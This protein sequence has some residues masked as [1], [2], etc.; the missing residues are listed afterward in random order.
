MKTPV[1][2]L[3]D[4]DLSDHDVCQRILAL[5]KHRLAEGLVVESLFDQ[6]LAAFPQNG[7]D[8]APV[9][10]DADTAIA[11]NP[12]GRDTYAFVWDRE[13]R[14]GLRRYLIALGRRYD[15][16]L[17]RF[18][19][20]E[21]TF[22]TTHIKDGK[23]VSDWAP[24]YE[25]ARDLSGLGHEHDVDVDVSV[26]DPKRINQ[27]FWGYLSA[28]Y[29]DA[30]G[31]RVV[32][33]RIFLNFGIQP[34][35]R[36]VWNIDRVYLQG[37]QIWHLEIKH[38]YPITGRPLTFGLNDGELRLI[39]NLSQCGLRSLHTII[40]KPRWNK[41]TSSMLL[42]NDMSA[43]AAAAVIGREITG[44][45]VTAIMRQRAGQ[46]GADTSFSGRSSLKFRSMPAS[47][48]TSFGTL[49]MPYTEVAGRIDR[50][51]RGEVLERITDERLSELRLA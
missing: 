15:T 47:G 9:L 6:Y 26:R 36:Y 24:L 33:P 20:S 32:L 37:D 22:I 49:G 29:G 23:R 48:F 10:I 31:E 19:A 5:D 16:W 27:S 46:S 4:L 8:D 34:W 13:S 14:I 44:E 25:T 11:A 40:V 45:E 17:V 38:K 51:M 7:N 42:T 50:F 39:R 35:F 18:D 43:R 12:R 3:K 30:L 28:H 21:N 2:N 1:G 41:E